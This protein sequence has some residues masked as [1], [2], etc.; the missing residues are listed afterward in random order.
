MFVAFENQIKSTNNTNPTLSEDIRYSLE[1]LKDIKD[2]VVM[3][4]IGNSTTSKCNK[5]CGLVVP[6]IATKTNSGFYK[7]WRNFFNF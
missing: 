2:L 5:T 3:H 1:I 7:L 4:N 6:S